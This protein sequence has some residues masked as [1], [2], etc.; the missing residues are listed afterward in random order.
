MSK[1]YIGTCSICGGDVTVPH[2][3]HGVRPPTPTCDSCGAVKVKDK[4]S[5]IPMQP[6]GSR[7]PVQRWLDTLKGVQ[8]E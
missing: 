4:G 7:Y 3:W 1:S 6:R 5:V 8:D 2:I